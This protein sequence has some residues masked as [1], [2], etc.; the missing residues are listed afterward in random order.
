MNT[1]IL[2]LDLGTRT[3]W[4]L[5]HSDGTITSGTEPFT[6]QRF[7]GGGM[8]F[9]RFKRWLNEVLSTANPIH[10]VYFEEVRRHAG[11]DAAHAYGGFMGHL[12]AWC[13]HHQIPYQGVPVGTI[14]KHAT[15]KGNASKDDMI[16]S[17]RRRGHTP[18]DDNQADAL[19][20]LHWAIETQGV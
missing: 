4:A 1:T 15:G 10:T 2:A 14:K 20:L 19:A 9:L 17:A 18:I 5:Q 13:E 11:V 6:P 16:A 3:G 12:T 8:R 7:E